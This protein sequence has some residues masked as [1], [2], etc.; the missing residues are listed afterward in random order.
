MHQDQAIRADR[1]VKHGHPVALQCPLCRIE[2]LE[3]GMKAIVES[4]WSPN[5]TDES[6]VLVA[7]L[8][9]QDFSAAILNAKSLLNH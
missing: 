3:A 1:A 4:C 7:P 9:H 5:P 2:D 8:K 6:Y